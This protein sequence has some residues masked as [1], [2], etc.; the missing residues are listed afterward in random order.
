MRSTDRPERRRETRLGHS[1]RAGCSRPSTWEL[2][3]GSVR[4]QTSGLR[5]GAALQP[6]FG[7]GGLGAHVAQFLLPGSSPGGQVRIVAVV[8]APVVGPRQLSL[9]LETAAH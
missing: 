8:L 2:L 1:P 5:A 9:Q 3:G 7:P 4:G 6:L